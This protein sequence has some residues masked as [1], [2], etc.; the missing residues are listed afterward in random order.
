MTTLQPGEADAE[1]VPGSPL[2][3]LES[4]CVFLAPLMALPGKPTRPSAP[5]FPS[6]PLFYMTTWQGSPFLTSTL[7]VNTAGLSLPH[8]CSTWQHCRA[9]LSST[10]LSMQTL[11]GHSFLTPSLHAKTAGFSLP[12]SSTPCQH[13]RAL[14]FSTLLSM[15]TLQS[16]PFLTLP[17]HARFF[18][19]DSNIIS[20]AK[21][22][23][24]HFCFACS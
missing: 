15:P 17:L 20:G 13:C 14:P 2:P 9:L 22:W 24:Q 18:L 23:V 11:Q 12:H 1:R 6:S 16:S 7:H 4:H 5:A 3:E 19:V 21:K 8:P 10:L